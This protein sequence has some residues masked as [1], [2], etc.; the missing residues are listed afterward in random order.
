MGDADCTRVNFFF[1]GGGL[2]F[3]FIGGV[4]PRGWIGARAVKIIIIVLGGAYLIY[5]IGGGLCLIYSG[6][7]FFIYIIYNLI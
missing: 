3:I 7:Y 5:I 1:S 4:T 2:Y 6:V